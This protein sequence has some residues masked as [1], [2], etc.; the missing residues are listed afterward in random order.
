MEKFGFNHFESPRIEV[1]HSLQSAAYN[2]RSIQLEYEKFETS[3]NQQRKKALQEI[4]DEFEEEGHKV[5]VFFG[6][7]LS[8][9]RSVETS[10]IEVQLLADEGAEAKQI[11]N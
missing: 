1:D 8:A 5:A 4:F 9:G 10:D 3:E 11:K 6:G 2:L 7:S